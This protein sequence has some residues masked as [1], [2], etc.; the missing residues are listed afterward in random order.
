MRAFITLKS[1][2][3]GYTKKP[4]ILNIGGFEFVVNNKSIRFDWFR[5]YTDVSIE[6]DGTLIIKAE[7][8]E[9]DT[10][11]YAEDYSRMGIEVTAQLLASADKIEEIFYEC[12]ADY[13]EMEF[14]P[15]VVTSFSIDGIPVRES[16]LQNYE[17]D[18]A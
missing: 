2:N 5:V 3:N 12:Y 7:V 1:K 13:Q 10:E 15:L 8:L 4:A 16:V 6:P 18:R 11:T 17:R 14:I 9:F